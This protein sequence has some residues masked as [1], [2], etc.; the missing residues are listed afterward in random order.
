MIGVG[1]KAPEFE[2]P[3]VVEGEI[4]TVALEDH[5]GEDVVVLAFYP[6]DFNPACGDGAA[7]LD[8]LDLFTMQKNVTVVGISADSVYSHRA[9]ADEYNLR[10]PLLSD[11]RGEVAAEYGVANG[12]R[13]AGCL[14]D[15][16]VVVVDP[17][18]TVEYTW[19]ADDLTTLP[20]AEEVRAAV[21][22]V[23]GDETAAARYRVGHARYV[24]GRRA[25][26]K[27]MHCFDD[28]EWVMA[29]K[30]FTQ[31]HEEFQVA[32]DQFD[33]AVRF[34]EDE[35][36]LA[37]YERAEQKAEA[38]WQAGEWLAKAANA[39]ASGQ[40]A[41][42][43][44]LRE[45]AEGLLEEAR[46]VHEPVA[47]DEFPPDQDPADSAHGE[48]GS[49][50]QDDE[51]SPGP[52]DDEE[53]TS[54]DLDVESEA[55]SGEQT[56]QEDQ[57][58]PGVTQETTTAEETTAADGTAAGGSTGEGESGGDES[59]D[60]ESGGDEIDEAELEEITAEL[61]AQT[62]R[63]Q[64]GESD[65][66]D[67]ERGLVPDGPGGDSSGESPPDR[68]GEQAEG[69][70]DSLDEADLD[71]DLSDPTDTENGDGEAVTEERD[72]AE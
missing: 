55:T 22:G 18:G 37:Y 68:A 2:L 10:I 9:F 36:E 52:P 62:E 56:G 30:D 20:A 47:P 58:G 5:L 27:A 13:Q 50:D 15:R 44:S 51:D 19:H 42:A 24:E 53:T 64:D 35:T 6:S 40:G 46:D 60:E 49:L 41:K 12:D 31:A 71:L 70:D 57:T 29:Q 67:A 59:G 38:L 7:D 39:F 21:E 33:A 61:E 1:E 34:V 25:F 23:S 43:E 66:A 28:R 4:T 72:D 14:T 65:P 3:A 26:T 69:E 48:G 63:T 32:A 45:D 17:D 16:A 8:D 54:L 11:V